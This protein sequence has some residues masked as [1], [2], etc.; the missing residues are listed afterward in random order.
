MQGLLWAQKFKFSQEWKVVSME[1]MAESKTLLQDFNDHYL[2][3][4]SF[5]TIYTSLP[6]LIRKGV[7]AEMAK[8]KTKNY[9]KSESSK[10]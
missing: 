5:K 1:F 2:D 10:T 9:S 6:N 3:G 7:C 4:Y 8:S